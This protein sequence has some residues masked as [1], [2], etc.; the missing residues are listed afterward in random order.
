MKDC[1]F[2]L[3]TDSLFAQ[4]SNLCLALSPMTSKR[5]RR[6]FQINIVFYQATVTLIS[7]DTKLM[8]TGAKLEGLFGG[9]GK[10][11]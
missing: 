2:M 1:V 5:E 6:C 11:S 7:F 8:Q 10:G 3:G 4:V 9:G